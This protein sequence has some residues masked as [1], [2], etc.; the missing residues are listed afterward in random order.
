[1]E[2]EKDVKVVLVELICD[3]CGEP[4]D[5][6]NPKVVWVNNN[7]PELVDDTILYKYSCS[8]DTCNDV[9]TSTKTY[10]YPRYLDL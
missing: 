3:S 1:M 8:N 2:T 9:Q 7:T 6:E 5:M 4:M 10:P